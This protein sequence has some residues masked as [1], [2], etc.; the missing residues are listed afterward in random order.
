MA[1]FIF[2][3]PDGQKYRIK[4]P[5]GSTPEQAF[6][7]LRGQIGGASDGPVAPMGSDGVSGDEI[8]A[9][10]AGNTRP[11]M[12]LKDIEAAY[13]MAKGNRPEQKAMAEAFVQ[14]E[15]ADSPILMGVSDRVRQVAK[16]VPVIGGALDEVN[17]GTAALFGNNYDKALDYER[18]RDRTF[19]AARPKESLGLQIGG[20]VAGTLAALPALGAAATGASPASTMLRSMATGGAIGAADGFG[21]GEDGLENRAKEAAFGGAFGGLVGGIAPVV[22]AGVS[23]GASKIADMVRTNR[24]VSALGLSRPAGDVINRVMSADD[25]LGPVGAANIMRGGPDAMLADAGRSAAGLLDTVIQ[26]GGPGAATASRAVS[27][28]A[29][30]AA[31]NVKGALD[32]SLGKAVGLETAEE[33]IRKGSAAS[34]KAAYDAAYATP[35]NYVDDTGRAIEDLLKRVPGDVIGKA[36]LL[37]KLR[38]EKSQQI[39]AKI[40]DDGSVAFERMPDVRQIDYIT[41]ALN[42]AAKSGDGQGALGGQTPLGSAYEGL[43][44]D[45]RGL[46]RQNVPAYGKALDTAADPIERRLALDFGS[47]MLSAGV[48]RDE[49]ART[50]KGMSKAELAAAKEGV[51][52]QIDDAMASV[53]RIMSDPNLD[54][55]QAT[56]ALR[57]LSSDAAR[58]K[59]AA[60]VGKAEADKLFAR[61]DEAAR[62]FELRAAVADNSKTYAR[63]AMSQATND[64]TAPGALGLLKSG[65]PVQAGRNILQGLLS[66]GPEAQIAAQDKIYNEIARALTERRGAD[67]QKLAQELSAAYARK[68]Q[69]DKGAQALGLLFAG[70][71]SGA[72]LPATSGQIR[73]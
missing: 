34:R 33:A 60:V 40:A 43:A 37:M 11:Q 4:G 61:L 35:V 73:R 62:A 47:K 2:T 24:D 57:D 1:E 23:K 27:D 66:S 56:K 70:G 28:R 10:N 65:N 69:F 59:V 9:R 12:S 7:I 6:E 15:R 30:V 19:E 36:N 72:A 48:T 14:R 71:A 41:R 55:R 3:A 25:A 8:R 51:R 63:Q 52:A 58:E 26:R 64:M 39:M 53:S 18:A 68:G 50:V 54:A 5:E 16:G 21:R 29:S 32:Q 13:D 46:M 42:Q 22:A 45:I 31:S 17:A 49:V 20:G 38:G 44:R 67:A